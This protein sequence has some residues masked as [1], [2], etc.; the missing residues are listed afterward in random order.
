MQL[1][2]QI[3]QKYFVPLAQI[4]TPS[5]ANYAIGDDAAIID[6]PDGK[7]LVISSDNAV[8]GVHFLANMAADDIA[9]RALAMNLSD[10]AAMGAT[11]AWFSLNICLP[12]IN[13]SWLELF[14]KGLK[15]V[16]EEFNCQLIGGNTSRGLEN[17]SIN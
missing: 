4:N 13:H 14:S 12:D 15:S 6:I 16:A 3:I 7:Q 17:L 1:E 9:W 5:P 10:I 8:E 2:D 11:P